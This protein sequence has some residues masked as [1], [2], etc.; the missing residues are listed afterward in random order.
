MEPTINTASRTF[1]ALISANGR[2]A[3]VSRGKTGNRNDAAVCG[4]FNEPEK[5]IM[6]EFER[7]TGYIFTDGE[8]LKTALT[9]SS[10]ANEH[11]RR[12][13]KSN[14]RL[15]FLGDSVLGMLVAE[16]LYENFPDLPEGRMTR[17]RA[18]FVCEQN[19][20]AAAAKLGL[21]DC[22]K[23]SKGEERSGGRVRPGI[24][25]DCVEAVI[26]ALYL[27]GGIAAAG[28]FV[29][30]FILPERK[31]DILN[32]GSDCKTAL[33]EL[34]QQKPGQELEY[35]LIGKSGPDHMREFTVTVSLNGNPIGEGSGRSKKEA[36]QSAAGN[37]MEKLKT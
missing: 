19:L 8:L 22:V 33:Q 12:K 29:K 23:L 11:N 31:S 36:E 3:G 13:Q 9:H 24:L 14:E 4:T 7:K 37:A 34:I 21:G 5:Q 25:S 2:A 28:D 1:P 20:Y 26:A 17:I 18:E 15:E 6:N 30:K 27:D 32:T 35:S 16:F 10:Y